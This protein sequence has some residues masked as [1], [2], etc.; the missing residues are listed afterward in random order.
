MLYHKLLLPSNART[1]YTNPKSCIAKK[2]YFSRKENSETDRQRPSPPFEGKHKLIFAFCCFLVVDA[3]WRPFLPCVIMVSKS[4]DVRRRLKEKVSFRNLFHSITEYWTSFKRRQGK[5][6]S[7]RPCLISHRSQ[8][9]SGTR[10]KTNR[11]SY[12]YGKNRK[13]VPS[14]GHPSPLGQSWSSCLA[15]SEEGGLSFWNS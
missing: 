5:K 2:C 12:F 15:A 10:R 3:D 6:P 14:C 1:P 11:E 13:S 8:R 7:W 4:R 9:W